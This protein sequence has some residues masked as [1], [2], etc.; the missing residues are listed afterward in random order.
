M[1]FCYLLYDCLSMIVFANNMNSKLN[2]VISSIQEIVYFVTKKNLPYD[3]FVNGWCFLKANWK[4]V[5]L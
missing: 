4:L 2:L 1:F 5:F 3:C